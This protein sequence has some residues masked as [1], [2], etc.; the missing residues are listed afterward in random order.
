MFNFH[1]T[2]FPFLQ[3]KKHPGTDRDGGEL[4]TFPMASGKLPALS[5]ECIAALG[6]ELTE[7][8]LPGN[9]RLGAR[10]S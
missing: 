10:S 4:Y 2:S 1:S 6:E 5:A 8:T 7:F 9:C 3:Q